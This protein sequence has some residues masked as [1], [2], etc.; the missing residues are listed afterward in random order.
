MV[1]WQTLC[2]LILSLNNEVGWNG[3]YWIRLVS[4]HY[5][6]FIMGAIASQITSLTIVY[7]TINSGTDQRKLQSSS[8]LAFVRGV[9]RWPVNSPHKWIATP[10]MFPFDDVTMLRSSPNYRWLGFCRILFFGYSVANFVY[11]F[12]MP[13]FWFSWLQVTF[14]IFQRIFHRNTEPGGDIIKYH[15]TTFF[16]ICK[17]KWCP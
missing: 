12:P 3:V 13:P 5:S 2:G 14:C 17:K 6:E 1:L 16:G 8:C 10:K 11:T 4:L 7:S 9:H 15:G